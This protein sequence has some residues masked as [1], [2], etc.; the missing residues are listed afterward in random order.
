MRSDPGQDAIDRPSAAVGGTIQLCDY[1]DRTFEAIVGEFEDPSAQVLF[2]RALEK[3]TGL[4]AVVRRNQSAVISR[5]VARFPMAWRAGEFEGLATLTAIV[6]HG[7]SHPITELLVRVDAPEAAAASG[8]SED[9]T[10]NLL[11]N[12]LDVLTRELADA[13]VS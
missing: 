6:L 7:G 9:G 1:V 10:I 11:R 12:F 3:V 2:E 8:L 13:T 4:P 5:H